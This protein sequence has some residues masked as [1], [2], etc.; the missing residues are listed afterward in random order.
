MTP[1]ATVRSVN[2]SPSALVTAVK[3]FAV[4]NVTSN[5]PVVSGS[6]FKFTVIR[7]RVVLA[8]IS[9]PEFTLSAP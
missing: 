4:T 6:M 2:E 8:M 9:L 3:S 7:F 5:F 1:D